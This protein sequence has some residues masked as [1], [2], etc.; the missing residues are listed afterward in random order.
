M[1]RLVDAAKRKATT[2]SLA[3]PCFDF[4]FDGGTNNSVHSMGLLITLPAKNATA[5][6][7]DINLLAFAPLLHK[8][9]FTEVIQ[10]DFFLEKLD[11]YDLPFDNQFWL[12]GENCNASTA[13][14]DLLRVLLQGC[15]SHRLNLA[16]DDYIKKVSE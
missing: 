6:S 1:L 16:V 11:W 2:L 9:Y 15:R 10:R 13:T 12:I 7:S 3:V 8:T 14:A 5:S 4:M